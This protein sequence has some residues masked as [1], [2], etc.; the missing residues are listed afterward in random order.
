MAILLQ[1]MNLL[2][3]AVIYATDINETV[4]ERARKGIFPLAICSNIPRTTAVGWSAGFL[5][6]LRCQL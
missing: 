1:E 5:R 4:L 6:I 3:K 2:H